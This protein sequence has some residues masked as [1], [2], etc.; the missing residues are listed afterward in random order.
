[1]IESQTMKVA[2]IRTGKGLPTEAEQREALAAAGVTD[3]ELAEAWVDRAPKRKAGQPLFEQRKYLLGAL[4]PGDEVHAARPAIIAGGGEAETL[5]FLEALTEHGA[6]LCIAST[7]ECCR[8]HPDAASGLAL[9]RA[10]RADERAMVLRKA[11]AARRPEK[12][13]PQQ[14]KEAK[15]HWFDR[16]ISEAEAAKRA[17]V[18]GRTM[19]RK[20]GA[21]GTEP[22]GGK[23]R[24]GKR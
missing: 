2:Y 5:A 24:K 21:R 12:L 15:R 4:R 20:W 8:W 16:A 23:N 3:A 10:A 6:V 19:R 11:R 22:F 18:S 9:M 17:G 13:T 14:W 1:M 7:R